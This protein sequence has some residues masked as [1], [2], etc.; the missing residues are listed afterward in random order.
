MKKGA[1]TSFQGSPL[2]NRGTYARI[3]ALD[4]ALDAF[5]HSCKQ[6]QATQCQVIS[7]G[8]GSDTRF[9]RYKVRSFRMISFCYFVK[10]P[11]VSTGY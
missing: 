2:I 7:L 8:A 11:F 4:Q 3:T 1:P 9:F 6:L 10:I 5:L